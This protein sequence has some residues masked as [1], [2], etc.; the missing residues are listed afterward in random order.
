MHPRGS[1]FVAPP[2]L[3]LA[4]LL[5]MYSVIAVAQDPARGGMRGSASGSNKPTGVVEGEELKDFHQA[6]ALQAT[7]QQ[8]ADFQALMKSADGARAE[9]L[10]F[11]QSLRAANPSAS[12][13]SSL[14]LGQALE[15]ARARHKSF[16]D[17]LST[18][19]KAGLRDILKRV[20]KA[21]SDLDQ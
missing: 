2:G 13:P 21:D 14:T 11:Q 5:L 3:I 10:V 15:N 6:L 1:A 17:G 18:E 12:S 4:S 8:V 7:G 9:L 20:G 16:Q 19:Q